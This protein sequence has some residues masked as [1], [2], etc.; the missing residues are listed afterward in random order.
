M[1]PLAFM[2][3]LR[4]VER[5]PRGLPHVSVLRRVWSSLW[6]PYM[7]AVGQSGALQAVLQILCGREL[8]LA[9]VSQARVASMSQP[10]P[11]E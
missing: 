6:F 11:F 8:R 10:M 9:S 4:T 3:F 2:S 1:F 5:Y 7:R